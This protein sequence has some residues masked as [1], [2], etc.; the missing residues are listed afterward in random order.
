[1]K[2]IATKNLTLTAMF[3][4]IGLVLP[5]LTWQIP[6]IGRMLLLMHIP[7]FLCGLICGWKYGLT[8]GFILPLLRSAMFGMPVMFP[9]AIAMAF[10]LATYGLIAGILY[11]RFRG[12]CGI[13]L[14]RSMIAAMLAGR[15][16]WGVAQVL[17]LGIGGSPFTWQM[18]ITGAFLSAIPGIVI[19]LTL[20]PAIM[21]ALNRT[22]LV[23]L[24]RE[25]PEEVGAAIGS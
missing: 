24:S 22:D 3:V 11:G 8:V 5:F 7:V 21:I 20:I 9:I 23:G 1:M 17:L 14:Y 10:E 16:V 13:V 6:Q 12:Q 18:F 15:I 2:R 19:Q 25:H 4:A